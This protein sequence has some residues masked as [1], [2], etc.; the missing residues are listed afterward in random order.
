L[1]ITL[2]VSSAKTEVKVPMRIRAKNNI[3]IYYS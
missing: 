3:F 1:I 2:S